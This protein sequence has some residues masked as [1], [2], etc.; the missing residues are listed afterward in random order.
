MGYKYYGIVVGVSPYTYEV[1]DL[2]LPNDTVAYFQTLPFI[3][4][5]FFH[6]IA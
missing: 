5:S 2:N 1:A 6:C 3:A 4:V